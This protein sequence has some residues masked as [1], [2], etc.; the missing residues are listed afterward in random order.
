MLVSFQPSEGIVLSKY[1]SCS[2][3]ACDFVSTFCER[4]VSSGY[5]TWF[6]W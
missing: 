6:A 3:L 2:M 1:I 5:N 4:K